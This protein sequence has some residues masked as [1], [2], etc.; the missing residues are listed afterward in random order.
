MVAH[1]ADYWHARGIEDEQAAPVTFQ[2]LRKH[3]RLV[4]FLLLAGVTAYFLYE[5]AV[6]DWPHAVATWKGRGWAL[7]LAVPLN[8]VGIAC[9]YCAW[10]WCYARFNLHPAGGMSIPLYFSVYAAQLVPMQLGRLIRPDAAVRLELG[11]LGK[12]VQAEAVL[13]Y[14]DVTALGAA[15]AGT[16]CMLLVP[17]GTPVVVLGAIALALVLA[18]GVAERVAGTRLALPTAFWLRWQNLAIVALR[19]I[20]WFI[21]GVILYTLVWNL[22]GDLDLLRTCFFVLVSSFIGSGTGIPGGLGATEGV[23]GWLLTLAELPAAHLAIAVGVFRIVTFWL[24]LPLGWLA[25]LRVNHAAAKLGH[26]EPE[27]EEAL[28]EV[29]EDGSSV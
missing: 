24:Q 21:L 15:I 4:G 11:R 22:P 2:S 19:M 25:L 6:S 1:S 9:D 27:L 17:W 13:F 7:G 14:L 12:A 3:A 10:R 5:F 16:F 23:L 28:Q 8:F 29:S 26:G 20:D 18:H